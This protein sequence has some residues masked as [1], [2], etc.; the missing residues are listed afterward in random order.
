MRNWLGM[1]KEEIKKK[2][3]VDR[4]EVKTFYMVISSLGVL[5][6]QSYNIFIKLLRVKGPGK[7]QLAKNWVRRM[8]MQACRG[9]FEL[10]NN[11]NENIL[12]MQ[13][14]EDITGYTESTEEITDNN[15]YA[16]NKEMG[17]DTEITTDVEH[18][19]ITVNG[20]LR[21]VKDFIDI[22]EEKNNVITSEEK[23][24]F[25]DLVDEEKEVEVPNQEEQENIDA[26]L[27]ED[28]SGSDYVSEDDKE[29]VVAE[30]GNSPEEMNDLINAQ[31][32]GPPRVANLGSSNSRQPSSH[33]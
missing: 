27:N 30:Q 29:R 20:K 6:A 25:I 3:H 28:D 17:Y 26:A 21:P 2:Y 16:L 32:F 13:H 8:I 22:P 15:L 31:R 24:K 19:V 1:Y 33:Q 12:K 23:V 5:Q 18:K 9:S 4:T 14:V 10:W 11:A 7:R